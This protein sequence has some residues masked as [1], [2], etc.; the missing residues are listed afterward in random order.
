[1]PVSTQNIN[2][3]LGNGYRVKSVTHQEYLDACAKLEDQIF[4]EYFNFNLNQALSEKERQNLKSLQSTM[5]YNF[6]LCL[7]IFTA[8]NQLVGW[9]YSAQE[10][11]GE[12]LMK[13]TGL[14]PAH[15][16]KGTYKL[17]LPLVLNI[18]KEIGFTSVLSYHRVIN[19]SVIVPKLKAGFLINGIVTDIYGTVV[20][21][22]YPFNEQYRE[23]FLVRSGERRPRGQMA[24]LLGL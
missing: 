15:Q 6:Q 5:N 7:G 18:F 13:D 16:R 1:M 8:E 9:Q 23:S 2:F 11:V 4:G 14:L 24:S 17:L 19:N 12:V 20:E 22:I 21:L 10:R 3:E